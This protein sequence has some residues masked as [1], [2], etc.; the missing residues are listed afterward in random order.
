MQQGGWGPQGW[1]APPP[2]KK[3]FPWL[4]V[5]GVAL[6]MALLAG[7]AIYL[8]RPTGEKPVPTPSTSQPTPWETSE[9]PSP[10]PTPAN[11]ETA[12]GPGT[13]EGVL[14]KLKS[15]GFTCTRESVVSFHS[16]LCTN[17]ESDPPR[18]V[19]YVGGTADG[20]LG[21]LSLDIESAVKPEKSWALSTWLIGQ[22]AG[23][24]RV[25]QI[26]EVIKKAQVD[27]YVAGSGP[28]FNF[29]GDSEGAIILMANAFPKGNPEMTTMSIDINKML[30]MGRKRGMECKFYTTSYIC[31][32]E[33]K[34]EYVAWMVRPYTKT[35]TDRAIAFYLKV[36]LKDEPA[37]LKPIM[38]REVATVLP[39]FGKYQKPFQDYI[40]KPKDAEG[41]LV[42]DDSAPGFIL[43]HLPPFKRGPKDSTSSFQVRAS[44]WANRDNN[45]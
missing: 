41:Q 10:V 13:V 18:M 39:L 27:E 42:Y 19:V 35:E 36:M 23:E 37:K 16:H 29:K 43:S 44:C 5:V 34:T 24:A 22:F 33:T 6:A 2:Q 9:S 28:G 32:K 17:F 4:A 3:S 15:E 45:C 26:Q 21:R 31:L 7:V 8:T 20:K 1:Q 30:A 14:S 11:E 25:A 40:N 12:P 38:D